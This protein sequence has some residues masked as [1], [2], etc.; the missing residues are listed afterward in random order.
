MHVGTFQPGN[1]TGWDSEGVII[2]LRYSACK[3]K[4]AVRGL[5]VL[6]P[7]TNPAN[8]NRRGEVCGGG[9]GGEGG[10]EGMR[11]FKFQI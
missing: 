9:G 8:N 10:G 4:M 6:P 11:K 5:S 3:K 7:T 1:V 2:T